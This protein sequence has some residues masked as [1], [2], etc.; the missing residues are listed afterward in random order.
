[1]TKRGEICFADIHGLSTTADSDPCGGCGVR[2]GSAALP[3]LGESMYM[4]VHT[5]F[6]YVCICMYL[7]A[8]TAWICSAICL[9]ANLSH[10]LPFGN[11]VVSAASGWPDSAEQAQCWTVILSNFCCCY[12][13]LRSAADSFECFN[14]GLS[15]SARC[16]CCCYCLCF[17][18]CFCGCCVGLAAFAFQM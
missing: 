5:I 13:L 8:P 3:Y 1:M 17:C 10:C 16:C 15:G 12:P 2:I 18:V 11:S 9:E 7:L 14:C 6:T 4:H